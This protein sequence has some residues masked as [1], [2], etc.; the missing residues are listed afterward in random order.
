MQEFRKES[1]SRRDRGQKTEREKNILRT[2]IIFLIG[3]LCIGYLVSGGRHF[4]KNWLELR[5]VEK[6]KIRVEVLN[7]TDIRGLAEEVSEF[8]RKEGFDIVQFGNANNKILE[9]VIIDRA[10]RDLKHARLVQ[11]ALK[12]GKL[13]FEP[14]PL[15]LLEV[16]VVV[17]HDLKIKKEASIIKNK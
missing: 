15:Q 2:L 8:L 1:K 11:A 9:T 10:D 3:I 5:G 17:G 4:I 6:S 14:H 16:T 13:D 12:Q 7:G